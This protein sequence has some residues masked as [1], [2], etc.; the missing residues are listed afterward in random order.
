MRILLVLAALFTLAGCESMEFVAVDYHSG[1]NYGPYI[2]PV[3][4]ISYT[5]GYYSGSHYNGY[6]VYGTHGHRYYHAPRNYSR[7]HYYSRPVVVHQHVH[8]S[9]CYARGGHSYVAPRYT[10]PVHVR[11]DRRTP[12]RAA[13]PSRTPPRTAPPRQRENRAN[14]NTRREDRVVNNERR[15]NRQDRQRDKKRKRK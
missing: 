3:N 10:P 9:S 1:H 2:Q 11:N 6:Q 8:V 13:P 12:P 14:N 5:L 7:H 15:E 4:H